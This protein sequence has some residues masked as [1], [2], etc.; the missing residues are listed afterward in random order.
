MPIYLNSPLT[1]AIRV[2]EHSDAVQ[3]SRSA[4]FVSKQTSEGRATYAALP[5]EVAEVVSLRERGV[6]ETVFCAV[7]GRRFELSLSTIS[8]TGSR[9]GEDGIE[10]SG[11]SAGREVENGMGGLE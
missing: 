5:P 6:H 2:I 10:H 7:H 9:E 8:R 4:I 1:Y 3:P 11:K